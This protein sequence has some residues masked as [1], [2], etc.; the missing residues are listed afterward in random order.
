MVWYNPCYSHSLSN[1]S[2]SASSSAVKTDDP[3][4]DADAPSSS[5]VS[6]VR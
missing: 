5:C 4:F 1:S 3:A 6:T 2:N